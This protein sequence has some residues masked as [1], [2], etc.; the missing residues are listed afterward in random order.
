MYITCRGNSVT[1]S[2][3]GAMFKILN[4][5]LRVRLSGVYAVNTAD[6]LRCGYWYATGAT[7]SLLDIESIQANQYCTLH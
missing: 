5:S 4:R 7:I 3:S 6:L 2:S 1:N